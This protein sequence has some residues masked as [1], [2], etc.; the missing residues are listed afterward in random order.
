VAAADGVAGAAGS[1]VT[2][3]ERQNVASIAPAT[4][5]R[6]RFIALLLEEK[7]A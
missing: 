5:N 4:A 3:P 6:D 2:A 7:T 1:A